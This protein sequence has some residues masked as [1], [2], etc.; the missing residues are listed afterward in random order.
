MDVDAE[1][2][3]AVAVSLLLVVVLWFSLRFLGGLGTAAAA[4]NESFLIS[5]TMM[6][7]VLARDVY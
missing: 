4:D 7:V 3:A 1:F 5:V 2:V 6:V